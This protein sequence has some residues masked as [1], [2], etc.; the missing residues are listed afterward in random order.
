MKIRSPEIC[1]TK[2]FKLSVTK[3]LI[4]VSDFPAEKLRYT[5]SWLVIKGSTESRDP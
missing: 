2:L 1:L 4:D 3:K 5:L